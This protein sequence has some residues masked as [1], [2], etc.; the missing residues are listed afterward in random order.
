[1]KTLSKII[2]FIQ[3]I[4]FIFLLTSTTQINTFAS[5]IINAD[6]RKISNVAVLLYSFDDLY[7]LEIKQKLEDLQN[8]TLDSLLNKNIDLFI[9]NLADTS[10]TPAENAINKIKITNVPV[11]LTQVSPEVVSKVSRYY[12]KAVFVHSTSE[13]EGILE[14]KILVDE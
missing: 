5:P 8:E 11:I 4:L 7:M 14:G 10:E 2:T 9:L 6:N 12:D 1:M 13:Q 3:F